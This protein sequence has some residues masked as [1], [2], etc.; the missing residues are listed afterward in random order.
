MRKR[1]V[2]CPSRRPTPTTATAWGHFAKTS[3]GLRRETKHSHRQIGDGQ[4][5]AGRAHDP[6]RLPR[7][8]PHVRHQK[9]GRKVHRL[10]VDC[11]EVHRLQV[12]GYT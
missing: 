9:D 5:G 12:S 4:E 11:Y 2:N 1:A 7:T 3:R 6:S 8:P 10:Q